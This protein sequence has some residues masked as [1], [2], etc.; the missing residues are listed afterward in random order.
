[1]TWTKL[2]DEFGPESAELTDGE[3]RTHVEALV[4]SNWR[5][6]DLY[7]PKAEVR[8]FAG[9][10][11]AEADIAGLV[12]KGWWQDAGQEWNIGLKFP[13]WQRDRKQVVSRREYLAE[14]QRRKRAHDADDHSRC[15]PAARC[16]RPSTVDA[17]VDTTVDPG[18]DGT[19]R[20]AALRPKGKS[21]IDE[22]VSRPVGRPQGG[23]T[24]ARPTP[25]FCPGTHGRT[26][27]NRIA[28]DREL[29]G[30][31]KQLARELELETVPS[32]DFG[33]F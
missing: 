2:G 7:V 3:F 25:K 8:R 22:Q 33:H 32:N 4:Y 1:M 24:S 23:S 27:R 19:G 5:L 31:C 9:S 26:C 17:T 20:E 21:S 15:L 30:V 13:D 28:Q 14:A 11:T 12:A 10:S 18:R 29:C 6:L 16:R